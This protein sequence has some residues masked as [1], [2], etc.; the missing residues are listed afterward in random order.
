LAGLRDL[1]VTIERTSARRHSRRS[2]QRR[3][4]RR[5]WRT[6]LIVGT[7]LIIVAAGLAAGEYGY[8]E[9]KLSRIAS[10]KCHSCRPA[11]PGK[12]FNV[13]VVGS[14][15]RVGDT[16]S[17]TRSFGSASQVGG[18]R[19]DT[20]KIVHV[21]P[22]TGSAKVLSIPRD[23]F[24]TL[25]GMPSTSTFS[26]ENKINTAFDDGVEP[27]VQTIQNTLGIPINH[28]VTIDF[29]GVIDLVNAVGTI[30]LD[31][32]FPVRDDDDG[33]NNSGL[34]IAHSGCQPIDGSEALA[35]ARSR[36]YEYYE[37]GSWHPDPTYDLGRI[38][39]QNIVMSAIV[40]KAKGDLN[41]IALN[42]VLGAVIG[43]ITKDRALSGNDLVSLAM[44]YHAFSGSNLQ[45]WTLPTTGVNAGSHGDV[46]VVQENQAQ[47][48]VNQFLG[49]AVP[50][51]ITT[52]PLDGTGSP[53]A[54]STANESS[55]S[56]PLPSVSSHAGPAATTTPVAKA[57]PTLFD[58]T[59][60]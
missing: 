42:R 32:P 18:Q 59:V 5:R 1:G 52:P 34:Q 46:E 24:V 11:T 51:R 56:L 29:S 30:S 37:D 2:R 33:N 14:D 7:A 31:F 57:T 25:S 50:L 28:F 48:A 22:A 38:E 54:P 20:I 16:A 27:L 3:T 40:D 13:L 44:R 4:P 41:P 58:P 15:S 17:A 35:L 53:Q 6:A 23:T 9:W 39:R 21:D 8:V 49:G 60:C 47:Q 12:P 36:Y 10:V 45:T 19:S 26:T 43:D 55:S